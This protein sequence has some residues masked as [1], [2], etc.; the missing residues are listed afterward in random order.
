M[1]AREK[2]KHKELARKK[3][4]D[5]LKARDP[6]ND[7]G[8]VRRHPVWLAEPHRRPFC[9]FNINNNSPWSQHHSQKKAKVDLAGARSEVKQVE[10]TLLQ[11]MLDL[12]QE[13]MDELRVSLCAVRADY[14]I[15]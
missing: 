12:Q 7:S 6:G 15:F 4:Y 5:R 13:K 9:L 1:S 14:A 8:I 3:H 2:I 10:Q 11:S